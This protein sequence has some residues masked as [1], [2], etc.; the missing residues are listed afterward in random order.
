MKWIAQVLAWADAFH[1]RRGKWPTRRS[2]RVDGVAG[3]TWLAVDNALRRGFRGLPSHTS[4]SQ[5]LANERNLVHVTGRRLSEPRILAWADAYHQRHGRWPTRRSGPIDDA[6]DLTWASVQRA[7]YY[8]YRGLPGGSSLKQLLADERGAP[9][10]RAR[11]LSLTQ[12]LAWADA[13][14]ARHG[15]WP[16]QRSGRVDGVAGTTWSAV[17]NALRRGFCDLP[18]STS[19]SRLLANERNVVRVSG[20]RLGVPRILAWADAYHQRH[21]RWPTRRS[22]RIDDAPDL[23]WAAVQRALYCGFR[24]LPGGSSL[25]QLLADERGAPR[26][27]ARRLSPTQILA[28]ADAYHA[29][30]GKWPSRKSGAVEGASDLTWDHVDAAL[31]FARHGLA[32]GSSLAELLNAERGARKKPKL[33]PLH[34]ARI[35]AWADAFR[36]RHGRWPS[37]D[38]GSI[39][40]VPGETW[41][42]VEA[43]LCFGLRGLDDGGS[44]GRLL[45]MR[46]HAA[47]PDE[48]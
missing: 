47:A 33:P 18:S 3:K 27:R 2:G 24:G 22:G 11:R 28:W 45:A 23:T 44:L 25:E 43:A 32:G 38:S 31:R 39:E 16:T 9:R 4:L 36:A 15:K 5:L 17:N 34:V 1:A 29:R 6:P 8:G 14:H 40:G 26:I 37:R 20:R 35:L 12:I 48:E 21:G 7:L 46:R 10:I 13:Y 41:S 19:L 30:H 42:K